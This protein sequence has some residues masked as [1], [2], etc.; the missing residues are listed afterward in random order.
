MLAAGPRD[1]LVPESGF[2]AA[3]EVLLQADVA[4]AGVTSPQSVTGERRSAAMLLL[5]I[6]LG[7]SALGILT[8]TS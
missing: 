3:R 2:E 8:T 6:L 5:G 1:V 7:A 4:V